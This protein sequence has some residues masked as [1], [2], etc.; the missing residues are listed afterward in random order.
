MGAKPGLTSYVTK[1]R[2][3]FNCGTDPQTA[4]LDF[5]QHFSEYLSPCQEELNGRP[6]GFPLYNSKPS[7][8]KLRRPA[9]GTGQ[10]R[11]TLTMEMSNNSKPPPPP[12]Q[13]FWLIFLLYLAMVQ[14]GRREMYFICIGHL[15]L[16]L[17]KSL[18]NSLITTDPKGQTI[19]IVVKA[20][21]NSQRKKL[22]VN[23]LPEHSFGHALLWIFAPCELYKS[24]SLQSVQKGQV[25]DSDPSSTGSSSKLRFWRSSMNITWERQPDHN[26]QTANSGP[27]HFN[28]VRLLDRGH[29]V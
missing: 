1:Q 6:C 27:W 10:S 29:C 7:T 15:T 8:F 21:K 12:W 28:W 16:I 18:C 4:R 3:L 23:P 24:S 13:T 22:K 9:W 20:I 2:S 14:R 26:R 11:L 17:T 19:F 25:F 5:K